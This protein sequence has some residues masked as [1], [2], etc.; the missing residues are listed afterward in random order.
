MMKELNPE[1]QFVEQIAQY[2]C[3][4]KMKIYRLSLCESECAEVADGMKEIMEQ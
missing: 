1:E 2:L 3:I 4:M